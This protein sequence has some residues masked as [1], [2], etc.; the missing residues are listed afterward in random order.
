M[1]NIEDGATITIENNTF[2]YSG[3]ALRLSNYFNTSATFNIYDNTVLDGSNDGW[4]D[5][6][7]QAVGSKSTCT[8]RYILCKIYNKC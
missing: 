3:N 1:F 7:F 5:Y 4:E 2:A 6:M 8:C